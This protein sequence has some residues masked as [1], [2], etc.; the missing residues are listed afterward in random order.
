MTSKQSHFI[1]A[2]QCG[3]TMLMVVK[4][5]RSFFSPPIIKARDSKGSFSHLAKEHILIFYSSTIKAKHLLYIGLTKDMTCQLAI[6]LQPL[7]EQLKRTLC[8]MV[9]C[10]AYG[11]TFI[12]VRSIYRVPNISRIM[13]RG[14]HGL[15]NAPFL[16]SLV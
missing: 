4:F 7:F 13:T 5:F 10:S 14:S 11:M 9:F 8:L 6:K 15:L 16:T 1:T 3:V 2:S 12:M